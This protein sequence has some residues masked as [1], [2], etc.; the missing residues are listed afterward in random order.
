MKEDT[1][2]D[3]PYQFGKKPIQRNN[4]QDWEEIK[5]SAVEGH[6]EQIPADIFVKHYTNLKA[7]QKDNM[8]TKDAE[9]LR[10]MWIWGK[11]GVGKSRRARLYAEDYNSDQ[12]QTHYPKL[13][14]KWWDGY[15]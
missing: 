8:V 14:N 15:Q 5:Q 1:R 10:G 13:C 11:A 4:K 7:I 12:S 9:G 6:L 3:G 2:V